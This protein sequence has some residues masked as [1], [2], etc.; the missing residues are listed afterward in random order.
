M[1]KDMFLDYDDLN[2]LKE[3]RK[4]REGESTTSWKIMK[5]IYPGGKERENNNINRKIKKMSSYGFFHIEHN[6]PTQYILIKDVVKIK[7][8]VINGKKYDGIALLINNKW[9]IFEI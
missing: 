7:A 4:L 6:S 5:K 1:I 9:Q 2:I 8:F 3:F